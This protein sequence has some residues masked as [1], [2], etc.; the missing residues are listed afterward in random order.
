MAELVQK[1]HLPHNAIVIDEFNF[2]LN[3]IN[4][5]KE[6]YTYFELRKLFLKEQIKQ[7]KLHIF[8]STY[9]NNLR[10][11]SDMS[12]RQIYLNCCQNPSDENL[13]L[14]LNCQ[15]TSKK[16][17]KQVF[18]ETV[19]DYTEFFA[20][21]GLL[22]TYYKGRAGGEHK[23]YVTQRLK[24]YIHGNISLEQLILDFKY[25]NSSKNYD[26]IDM[27][28]IS[29]RPYLIA[30]KACDY[31]FSKGYTKVHN[32]ILSA[33]VLYSK[34][35]DLSHI[36]SLFEDPTKNIDD[37]K[38]LFEEDKFSSIKDELGRATLQLRPYLLYTNYLSKEGAYY[39]KGS[40]NFNEDLY[41]SKVAF[42]NSYIGNLTI[43][44]VVGKILYKLYGSALN[45]IKNITDEELFDQ[46]INDEDKTFLL[47][48]LV[49]LKCVSLIDGKIMVN[50]LKYQVAVNPYSDFF[51][52][53]DANYVS[54]NGSMRLYNEPLFV[55]QPN[56]DI[57]DELNRIKPIALGSDGSM[58]EESIYNL[59][60]DNFAIFN[61]KW[62][63]AN[64]TGRR[65]SD[66][67]IKTKV[68]DG[69]EDK[70]IAIIIECKAGRA[71][72]SFD[73]R[74]EWDDISNTLLIEKS[75]GNIDGIWYWVV[76]GDSLPLVNEHGGY[77]TNSLSKSF[78]EK[79]SELQFNISEYMRVPTIVTAFSFDSIK[80]Y[81]CYLYDKLGNTNIDV[82]NKLD[83]PHFWR[84]SKKFMNLQYVMV[85]K[86]LRLGA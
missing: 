25:R 14:L 10:S 60:N 29:V 12:I 38:Q 41:A 33:I 19:R 72:R 13:D 65:L 40:R 46:N 45:G 6:Y 55:S 75:N 58:Y 24:E 4:L 15:Y 70:N 51:D 20:F 1:Y 54:G 39:I 47:Q 50:P 84:W 67:F 11:H 28:S 59:I 52:I 35:E 16:T 61:T 63:G 77:R 9:H 23:H 53:N 36:L 37:Y 83:V 44:P 48:E 74:K 64:A 71:I 27:Y 7:Q 57:E 18:N 3:C 80:N 68:K 17:F 5:N 73:E 66:I 85:H 21:L 42:C 49:N 56:A 26:V 62:Y 34:H 82:I 8:H 2:M 86:D 78:I 79:L 32:K 76:N 43:T 81:L 30:L 69:V 31:Y 22:P